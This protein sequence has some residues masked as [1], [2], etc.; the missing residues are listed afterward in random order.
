M[1]VV[2][3]VTVSGL[4]GL[5]LP[6]LPTLI[7]Q[8]DF[9]ECKQRNIIL[10]NIRNNKTTT[11]DF[12]KCLPRN[13]YIYVREINTKSDKNPYLWEYNVLQILE[14]FDTAV[15][16]II[17]AMEG[18]LIWGKEKSSKLCKLCTTN[19]K[20]IIKFYDQGTKCCG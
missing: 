8:H 15:L 13:I 14:L 1:K 18:N 2:V 6:R 19:S 4:G 10:S 12:N 17:I 3:S 5:E 9:T 20:F 11:V 16:Y 7:T